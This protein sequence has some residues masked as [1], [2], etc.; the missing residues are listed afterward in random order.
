MSTQTA[1]GRLLFLLQWMK[2]THCNEWALSPICSGRKVHTIST[3]WTTTAHTWRLSVAPAQMLKTAAFAALVGA[4]TCMTIY[5]ASSAVRFKRFEH[6]SE[7]PVSQKTCECHAG[8]SG[9]FHF[10]H[11]GKVCDTVHGLCHKQ[12]KSQ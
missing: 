12:S 7:G 1:G 4:M 8:T 2:G 5:E 9:R 6:C 3:L 10:C 11:A